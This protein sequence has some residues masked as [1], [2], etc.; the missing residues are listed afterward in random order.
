MHKLQYEAPRE[1]IDKALVFPPH[2][3]LIPLKCHSMVLLRLLI[4]TRNRHAFKRSHLTCV[5][6]LKLCAS[7]PLLQH[8]PLLRSDFLPVDGK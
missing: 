4:K 2:L 3:T 5:S 7:Q 8:F 6:E 1:K